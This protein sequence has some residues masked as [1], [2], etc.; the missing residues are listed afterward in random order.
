MPKH[1]LLVL[2]ALQARRLA[3]QKVQATLMW[4]T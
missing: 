1:E 2:I 3:Y 4:T